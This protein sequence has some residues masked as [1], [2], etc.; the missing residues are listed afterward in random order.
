MSEKT[1]DHNKLRHDLPRRTDN[2]QQSP[3]PDHAFVTDWDLSQSNQQSVEGSMPP[4]DSDSSSL[5][6]TRGA[7]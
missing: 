5:L 6:F 2:L 7:D 3:S 1:S 4:T